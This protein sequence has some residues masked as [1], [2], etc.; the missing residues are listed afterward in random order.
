MDTQVLFGF[1]PLNFKIGS[2]KVKREGSILTLFGKSGRPFARIALST[3]DA[4][5]G[6]MWLRNSL[7]G[8]FCYQARRWYVYPIEKG[9]VSATALRIDPL[10][11]LIR[12]YE[13]Q[14]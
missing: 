4:P 5:R 6:A 10:S 13:A 9:Q 1:E 12:R 2:H 14:T 8:E 11:Y 3:S 7:A